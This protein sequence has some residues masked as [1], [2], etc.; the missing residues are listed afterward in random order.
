MTRAIARFVPD[1]SGQ[2]SPQS[3]AECAPLGGQDLWVNIRRSPGVIE[4]AYADFLRSEYRLVL[5]QEEG[6][7]D[8]ELVLSRQ[9]LLA[10][11]ERFSA[12]PAAADSPPDRREAD[13]EDSIADFHD[14]LKALARTDKVQRTI[15]LI[16]DYF[17]DL[18]CL[19]HFRQA[20][21][22]LQ[23]IGTSDLQPVFLAAILSITRPAHRKLPSRGLFY[24]AAL[25]AVARLRDEA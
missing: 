1:L 12:Q 8:R 11:Q 2:A 6:A 22:T 23:R 4:N 13:P 14:S 15:D 24:A 16:F 19:G 20:D 5:V 9:Q 17:D 7:S 18:L 21:R 25:R 3:K 10:S